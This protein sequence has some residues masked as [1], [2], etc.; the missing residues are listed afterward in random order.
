MKELPLPALPDGATEAI[1]EHVY[2]ASGEQVR[3]GQALALVRT[4]RY[5]YD[6]PAPA[7]GTL[8]EMR[9]T[10]GD[11]LSSGQVLAVLVPGEPEAA[12][13]DSTAG[14]P[15][16]TARS[17]A[18]AAGALRG[19]A[20]RATP[21]ARRLATAKAIDL[22]LVL[23]RTPPLLRRADVLHY[24]EGAAKREVAPDSEPPRFIAIERAGAA[25]LAMS[26]ME[27]DWSA[28]DGYLA[29]HAGRFGR[30]G[31]R[32]DRRAC[33]AMAT[34]HALVHHHMVHA[35]WSEQGIRLR[36]GVDIRIG[37]HVVRGAADLSAGGIARALGAGSSAGGH[38]QP[39][40]IVESAAAMWSEAALPDGASAVLCVG[41]AE[42]RLRAVGHDERIAARPISL[43]ALVYDARVLDQRSADRFLDDVRL[44]LERIGSLC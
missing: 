33:L 37:E 29:R 4:E 34:A 23:A 22:A 43:M 40:V 28:P 24:L 12:A 1:V 11:R 18:P 30:R 38:E 19:P 5:A 15:L 16:E 41:H 42:L 17:L 14:A 27:I 25:P 36:R 3:R 44:G 8:A 7:S 35:T 9:V 20:L 6:I 21:L 2:A 10:P 26:A 13:K 39:F 31:A 32:L